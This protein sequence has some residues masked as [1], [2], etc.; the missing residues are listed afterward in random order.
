MGGIFAGRAI[1]KFL[2]SG[3]KSDLNEY[4]KNWNEKFKKEFEK[5]LLAR[6]IL[7]RNSKTAKETLK[8]MGFSLTDKGLEMTDEPVW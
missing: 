4:K 6:K 2:D 1:S 3:K 7:D 5:Q 8:I